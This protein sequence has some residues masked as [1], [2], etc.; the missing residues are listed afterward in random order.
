MIQ[1]NIAHISVKDLS[2]ETSEIICAILSNEGCEGFEIKDD[3]I[4]AYVEEGKIC[5]RRFREIFIGYANGS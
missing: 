1:Y 2:E 3:S 5:K 4:S